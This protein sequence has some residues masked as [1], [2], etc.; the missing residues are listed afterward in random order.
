[1]IPDLQ[2][3]ILCDDVRQERNGKFMLIGIFEGLGLPKGRQVAPRMCLVNRWC[4][5][6]G[7]FTQKTRIVA[8][9]GATVVVESQPILV[10]LRDE[11]QTATSVEIFVNVPFKQEGIHWVEI[12]LDQTMEIR[13]PLHVKFVDPPPQQQSPQP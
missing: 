11:T 4:S 1:M 5:G 10:N 12:M 9:D 13:Y 7:T 2:S 8:P 6:K 3:S